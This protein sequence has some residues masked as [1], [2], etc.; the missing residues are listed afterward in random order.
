MKEREKIIEKLLL[1]WRKD[2]ISFH[3]NLVDFIL[4]DRKRICESL[5]K[6]GDISRYSKVWNYGGVSVE[7]LCT[8]IE[9]TL[10][11]AGLGDEK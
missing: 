5:I 2:P 1:L 11:L 10:N 7:I 3:E 9:E 4:A 6:L 8:A